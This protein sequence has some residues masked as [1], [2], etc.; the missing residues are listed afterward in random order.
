VC[1]SPL[2]L[3]LALLP[4]A[5]LAS[6]AQG[7]EA[8]A[9]PRLN[10]LLLIGDDLNT[11]LGCYGNAVKT[12]NIDRIARLGVRFERAYCQFPLCN[13]SRASLFRSLRPGASGKDAV[14]L[15]DRFREGGYFTAEVG[16]VTPHG[17]GPDV[18]RM[19]Q[20]SEKK[21][22]PAAEPPK[23]ERAKAA[24]V[25]LRVVELLEKHRGGP[26]FIGAGFQE[27]HPGNPV[28]RKYLTMY[29]PG[30][31][32]LPDEPAASIRAVPE[33]ARDIPSHYNG[34]QTP[35]ERRK[36]IARY[37]GAVSYI[38]TQVGVILDALERLKLRD[39]TVV[40][41]M[42]DHGKHLGEHGGFVGKMTLYEEAARIPLI[43]SVPGK[44]AGTAR[45]LVESLDLY[46]TL[47]ELCGL[48]A[49]RGL[50]GT[51]FAPLLDDP[52]R[53]GKKAAFTTTQRKGRGY[54]HSV[55]TERYRFCDWGGEKD[56]Q[57]FDHAADPHEYR[58]LAHDPK[59]AAVVA[60]M[61]ELLNQ[62]R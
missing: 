59:Y 35:Q 58:N 37:H 30:K 29:D 48:P 42:S 61:R 41:L 10:V 11:H 39:R 56:A 13:P 15:S 25:A 54:V 53:Q 52:A 17:S 19:W 31:V 27:T 22:K 9:R 3:C 6:P 46:P 62:S 16:E 40:V 24:L 28:P 12:P 2:T 47:L 38:D 51:S 60:E 45:G 36:R 32:V 33:V 8:K 50:H 26:F 14:W 1:R 23:E 43:V 4:L 18:G 5:G 57:L 21:P 34:G 7:A 20:L 44:K 55:R 49:A